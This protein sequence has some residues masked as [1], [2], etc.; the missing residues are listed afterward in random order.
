MLRVGKVYGTDASR[1]DNYWCST[2]S[3]QTPVLVGTRGARGGWA[4]HLGLA[5]FW[6]SG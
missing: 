5:W 1:F 3:G 4:V 6:G 2:L